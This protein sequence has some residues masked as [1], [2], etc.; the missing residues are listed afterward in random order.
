M[1][2]PTQNDAVRSIPIPTTLSAVPLVALCVRDQASPTGAASIVCRIGYADNRAPD[3]G[4]AYYPYADVGML[5]FRRERGHDCASGMLKRKHFATAAVVSA[6]VE[7]VATQ[8]GVYAQGVCI[9]LID[10]V[11]CVVENGEEGTLMFDGDG[12]GGAHFGASLGA[13]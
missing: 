7:F 5:W 1:S 10:A 8:L 3:I 12:E 4:D 9:E 2:S 11:Q 13:E 6:L